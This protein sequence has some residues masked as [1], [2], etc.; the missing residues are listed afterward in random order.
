MTV[1]A[2]AV[3]SALLSLAPSYLDK[4][5]SAEQRTELL[6]PVAEAIATVSR[7]EYEAAAL[8]AQGHAES[9]WSRAVL[10]YR[11]SDLGRLACDRGKARGPWQTHSWCK[12]RGFVAEAKCTLR[13]MRFGKQRCADHCLNPWLGA[14][15]ACASLPPD[16]VGAHER[17]KL[18]KR[19]LERLRRAR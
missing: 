19:V 13:V 8:I 4:H 12:E 10:E 18:M 11:C 14:F 17:V 3:L 6:R 2:A 5:E 1:S 7:N 15:S 9:K 16:W